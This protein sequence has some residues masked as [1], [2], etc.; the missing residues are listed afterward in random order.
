VSDALSQ[1]NSPI[2]WRAPVTGFPVVQKNYKYKTKTV[3]AQYL[4][5]RLSLNLR[6][7]SDTELSPQRQRSA[8]TA[9]FIHC[10]DAAH[11]IITMNKFLDEGVDR[12]GCVH[13]S[14][15]ALAS[16]M[17]LLSRLTRLAFV[18]LHKGNIM[19]SFFET[20]CAGLPED[21]KQRLRTSMPK[22][23]GL[24]LEQVVDSPYLFS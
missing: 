2:E 20:A 8:I 9:N 19:E 21:V 11:L 10:L 7:D 6:I 1:V 23:R 12:F 22:Q 15:V 14:Y 17:E 4:G 16:D 3:Q 24:I 5:K 13:D 18:E